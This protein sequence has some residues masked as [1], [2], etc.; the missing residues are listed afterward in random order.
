MKQAV[1]YSLKVW[2]TGVFISPVLVKLFWMIIGE[3][4]GSNAIGALMLFGGILSIPSVLLLFLSVLILAKQA[5]AINLM[6]LIL[7]LIGIIL[8]YLPI[9][10]LNGRQFGLD[11]FMMN[12][13]VAYTVIIIA[14]I[15]FY[16]LKPL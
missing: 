1:I 15:W 14:G 7:S 11:S 5:I 3:S 16:K 4:S 12:F 10:F 8:T 9:W 2:F 13:F 6:K